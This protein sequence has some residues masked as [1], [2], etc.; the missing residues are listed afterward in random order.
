MT[1]TYTAYSTEFMSV[2]KYYPKGS[3]LD[4][5]T[6]KLSS[7]N[8]FENEPAVVAERSKALCNISQLIHG[9]NPTQDYNID[10]S[11]F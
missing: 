3:N 11:E 5:M 6:Q 7:I 1:V 8:N 4:S 10:P 9:L 2:T